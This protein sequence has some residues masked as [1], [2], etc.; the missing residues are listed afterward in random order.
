[1]PRYSLLSM[2]VALVASF[3]LAP[4]APATAADGEVLI[5]HAKA[6]AGGVTAG[7]GPGYPVTLSAPGSYKLASNLFPGANLDGII[8][9]SSYVAID[10]NGF[11]LLGA[12]AIDGVPNARY[13]IHAQGISLTVKN[14]TIA[15]F[16]AASIY[17]VNKPELVV[18]NMTIVRGSGFGIH[19]EAGSGAR[20]QNS[21]IAHHLRAGIICGDYCHIEGNVIS[22][23][24]G[25]GI[26]IRSGTVLGNTII[27]NRQLGIVTT[28]DIITGFGNNTIV[29]NNDGGGA[30]VLGSLASLHPNIC[31]PVAC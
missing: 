3:S 31:A 23:N 4:I 20:I 24:F 1:M 8:V 19:N 30:Q 17:A 28:S 6:L 7:D 9:K 22:S 10:L 26:L 18:E 15:G 2:L 27:S 21:T 29:D 25:N 12:T 5:T 14:G 13:G 11:L 16:K